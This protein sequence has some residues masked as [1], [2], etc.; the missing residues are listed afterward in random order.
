[1]L[2]GSCDFQGSDQHVVNSAQHSWTWLKG[3]I[4]NRL[5]PACKFVAWRQA[6]LCRH[7]VCVYPSTPLQ[8]G[9]DT[10]TAQPGVP[11]GRSARSSEVVEAAARACAAQKLWQR[12]VLF[13]KQK[14]AYK[15]DRTQNNEDKQ[16][17]TLH[18]VPRRHRG[19]AN[20]T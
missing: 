8:L 10:K 13:N 16:N 7:V 1:M 18:N 17:S 6:G 15:N 9:R 2:S 3:N 5:I 11:G 12:H 19:K 4:S 14:E 20:P